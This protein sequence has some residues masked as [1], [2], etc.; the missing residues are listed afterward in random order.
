[1]T[2]E[3]TTATGSMYELDPDNRRVRRVESTHALRRDGDW[4][5]VQNDPNPEIGQP[6]V[7]FLE[8]LGEGTVTIRTTS[9]VTRV[10]IHA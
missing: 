8:P 10:V 4:L 7:L 6:M 2:L 1:M 3:V 9:L 5:H